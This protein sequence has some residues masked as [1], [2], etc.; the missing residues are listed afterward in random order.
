VAELNISA[1]PRTEFGKGGARRTRRAGK[2]PAVLYGHGE[3]PRH[4]ALPARDFAAALRTEAGANVLLRVDCNGQ[5]DLALPKSVQRDPVRGTIEHADL[6]I[7]RRGERVN[8]DVAVQLTGEATSDGLVD[9]QLTTVTVEA[10][11]TAIP[12]GLVADID[13]LEIGGAVTAGQLPLP[14][15]VVLHTDPDAIVVHILA[16]P[17]AAQIEAEL[18][19]AEAEL[20]A[21]A[22]GAAAEEAAQQQ[23]EGE[24]AAGRTGE[25]DVVADTGSG[26][27]GPSEGQTARGGAPAPAGAEPAS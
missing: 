15:G 11:A 12:Q 5:S 23:V 21:G 14:A 18:A 8:V 6:I 10:D 1:E 16:A 13:G 17:T 22:A 25:G 9:Q 7:V 26:E 24:A 2:V 3:Q 19:G 20:G 27:G 4:I